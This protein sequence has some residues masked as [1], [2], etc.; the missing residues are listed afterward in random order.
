MFSDSKPQVEVYFNPTGQAIYKPACGIYFSS[1]LGNLYEQILERLRNP[2]N[3]GSDKV[4]A[5]ALRYLYEDD[6]CTTRSQEPLVLINGRVLSKDGKLWTLESNLSEGD[7][8]TIM[9]VISGG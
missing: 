8:I 1:S 3:G 6:G 5:D 2:A 9:M 4:C 7:S